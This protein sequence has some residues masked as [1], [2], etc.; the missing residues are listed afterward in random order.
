M[1]EGSYKYRDPLV[2][3]NLDTKWNSDQTLTKL[4]VLSIPAIRFSSCRAT[5]ALEACKQP[6]K[7]TTLAISVGMYR[8]EVN[9]LLAGKFHHI[10]CIQNP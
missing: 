4:Q 2:E 6:I 1:G 8:N 5:R 3:V 7:E 9:R 10:V